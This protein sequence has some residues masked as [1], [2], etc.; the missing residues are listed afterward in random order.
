MV[1]VCGQKERRAE[2]KVERDGASARPP[3]HFFFEIFTSIASPIAHRLRTSL[4]HVSNAYSDSKLARN[5]TTPLFVR[6]HTTAESQSSHRHVLSQV[7]IIRKMDSKPP[8]Y[9]GT[10]ATQDP[11]SSSTYAM[12]GMP[13]QPQPTYQPQQQ[14]YPVQG[15]PPAPYGQQQQGTSSYGQQQ[16]QQQLYPSAYGAPPHQPVYQQ[17]QPMYY[18]QQQQ[19]AGGAGGGDTCMKA[20]YGVIVDDF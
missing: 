10:G 15:Y 20:W 14:G 18:G 8:A 5:Q 6:Q 17:Q 3:F 16:Q 11:S 7:R 12:H 19:H 1:A 4:Q 2:W 13:A 9:P